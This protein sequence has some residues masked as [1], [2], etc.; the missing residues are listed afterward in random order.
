M[1]G[2]RRFAY[3]GPEGTFS[4]EA[5]HRDAPSEGIERVPL[6]SI[7]GTVMAVQDRLRE[8][9]VLQ[10]LGYSGPRVFGLVLSEGIIVSLVGGVIGV[11]AALAVLWWTRLA[12]GTEGVTIALSPSPRR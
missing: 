3:L 4:D 7:Y 2:V 8:H 6:E 11:G 5:L 9:A 10:A 12:V 1:R